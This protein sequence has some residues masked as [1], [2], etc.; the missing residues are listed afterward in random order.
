MVAVDTE[1]FFVGSEVCTSAVLTSSI[2]SPLKITPQFRGICG[3]HLQSVRINQARNRR[4]EASKKILYACFFLGLLFDP[5]GGGD[6][7]IR[8]AGLLPTYFKALYP[9][10][11]NSL[12]NHFK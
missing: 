3:L 12:E 7:F 10:R 8:N 4:E 2:F 6:V 11:Q 9:R 5:E 1:K